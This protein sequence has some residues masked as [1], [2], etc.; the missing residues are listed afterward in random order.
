MPREI[1]RLTPEQ[2]DGLTRK[3]WYGDGGGLYLRVQKGGTKSWV[4]VDCKGGRRKEKGLGPT[5][6][7]S[8]AEARVFR[9]RL[10]RKAN[11]QQVL[12]GLPRTFGEIADDFIDGWEAIWR[13]PVHRQQWRTTLTSHAAAL[14]DKLPGEITP[15]DVLSVIKPLWLTKNETASRLRG[16]I[17]RILDAAKARGHIPAPWEN[18]ARWRGHLEHLLPPHRPPKRHH[19][20]VPWE[21]MPALWN[22]L[23]NRQRTTRNLALRFT[24]L[25]AAR[26]GEVVGARWTEIDFETSTWTIPGGRMKGGIEHRVP[27]SGA[28]IDVLRHVFKVSLNDYIFCRKRSRQDNSRGGRLMPSEPS[29]H[30]DLLAALRTDL[31]RTE[32]VHGFRSSF[33]DWAGDATDYPRELAEMALA[34]A[35]GDAVE[36]A[37]RRGRALERRRPMMED[38]ARYLHHGVDT[39]GP[40]RL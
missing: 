9:D 37:Y 40:C 14:Q 36:Q 15:D 10:A 39:K 21:E 31:G 24:I 27:L 22:E 19:A 26:A 1:N 30:Y 16:R 7:V 34:H 20:A 23:T 29:K 38:W 12:E 13:N 2:V 33:R 28:A 18:P 11:R 35:V 17:E 32:T 8:L 25:T 5:R 6:L 3:G 4:F